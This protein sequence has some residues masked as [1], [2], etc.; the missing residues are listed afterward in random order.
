MAR[1][2]PLITIV[3]APMTAKAGQEMVSV[4]TRPG[5]TVR[6][7]MITPDSAPKGALVVFPGGNGAGHF[8][9]RRGNIR[10]G[11]NFLVRSADL[12]VGQGL[13]AAI[14]DVPS[15]HAQ[16]MDFQFRRSR[17]H[18]ED[19]TKLLDGLGDKL[20]KPIFLI[21]TSAGTVSVASF[22]TSRNDPRLA[23][24][25][26]TAS[27]G[28]S[29]GR[30]GS[31]LDLPLEKMTGPVLFVH[32]KDDAC[33]A[34][35]FKEALKIRDRVAKNV[36]TDFIAVLGGDPPISE[37]CEAKSTHGFLGKEREVVSAIAD[38]IAGRPIPDTIG[39]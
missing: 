33:W 17:E 15:D 29:R 3:A 4:S 23:G 20:A 38:W 28:A 19:V 6:V 31:L 26:L 32:H 5:V 2:L 13:V 14:V 36:K 12:F 27:I 35:P 7:L 21:G 1:V 9:D 18:A 37:P 16:G 39:P 25:I 30:G 22:G 10:L 24:M 8:T 11:G 34:S